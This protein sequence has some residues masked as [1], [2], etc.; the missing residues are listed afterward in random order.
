MNK[1]Y[2]YGRSALGV[3]RDAY[4]LYRGVKSGDWSELYHYMPR[5]LSSNL[6]IR[7][8]KQW[9]NEDEDYMLLN[10]PRAAIYD[11]EL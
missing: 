5:D 7:Q 4:G 9:D 11:D 3:A 6:K 2:A 8:A 1:A 10:D